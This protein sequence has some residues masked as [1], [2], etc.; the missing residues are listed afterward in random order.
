MKHIDSFY[1]YLKNSGRWDDTKSNLATLI[2][3]NNNIADIYCVW[4]YQQNI[5]EA[6]EEIIQD[7]I[8]FLAK[9]MNIFY[10]NLGKHL[11]ENRL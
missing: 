7:N 11:D 10:E 6:L 5:I 1:Q 4:E 8:D 9:R 3:D 2:K